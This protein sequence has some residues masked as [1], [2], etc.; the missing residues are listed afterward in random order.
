MHDGAVPSYAQLV[1]PHSQILLRHGG[2]LPQHGQFAARYIPVLPSDDCFCPMNA[3]FLLQ[4]AFGHHP[5]L[6]CASSLQYSSYP[7][8]ITRHICDHISP[9]Y[10]HYNSIY[11]M[12]QCPL[13]KVVPFPCVSPTNPILQPIGRTS[14][15]ELTSKKPKAGWPQASLKYVVTCR[16]TIIR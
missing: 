14:T 13:R 6:A 3:R 16:I 5:A 12:R 11:V 15:K 8:R 9:Y 1:L 2:A 4:V 7:P 10:M